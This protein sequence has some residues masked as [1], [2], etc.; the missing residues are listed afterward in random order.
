M[1]VQPAAALGVDDAGKEKAQDRR[2]LRQGMVWS[3]R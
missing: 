1:P 2:V 3:P